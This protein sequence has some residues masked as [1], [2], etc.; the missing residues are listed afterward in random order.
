M[1]P[2]RRVLP[3]TLT[4]GLIGPPLLAQPTS[5]SSPGAS[6]SRF[7]PLS[8]LNRMRERPEGTEEAV[9]L[10][11]AL[12]AVWT[13]LKETLS[14]LSVP[15]E[16]EDPTNGEIG[17]TQAK[18]FRK[19]GKQPLSFILRCGSGV[20]GPNADTYM[21]YL[22][23]VAFVKPVEGGNIAVAPL[24]TGQAQDPTGSRSDWVNCTST[25]RLENRIAQELRKRL[26]ESG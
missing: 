22:S 4:L 9:V 21:V 3:V 11:A 5:A 1:S 14:S 16:F 2:V 13:A 8:V 12:P 17:H 6:M 15:I 26:P 10:T 7:I 25:G 20:T 23:F 24:L 19:L 18:L